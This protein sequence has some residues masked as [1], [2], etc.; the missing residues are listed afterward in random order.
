ME[1]IKLINLDKKIKKIYDYLVDILKQ[2]G[3][4]DNSLDVQI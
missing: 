2:K 1:L 4:Y 3:L